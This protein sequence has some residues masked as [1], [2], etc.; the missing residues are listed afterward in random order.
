MNGYFYSP[1][2]GAYCE[3]YLSVGANQFNYRVSYLSI[4]ML[5]NCANESVQ[6]FIRAEVRDSST[7]SLHAPSVGVTKLVGKTEED[8]E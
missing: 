5:F 2:S 7:S 1:I 4:N 8:Y 6:L 3:N